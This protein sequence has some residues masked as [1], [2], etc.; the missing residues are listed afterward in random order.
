MLPLSPF[1]ASFAAAGIPKEDERRRTAEVHVLRHTFSTHLSRNGMAPRTASR[2]FTNVGFG[3]RQF[4]PAEEPVRVVPLFRR[5]EVEALQPALLAL[6]NGTG[7]AP[8]ER[9]LPPYS[10]VPQ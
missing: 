10:H 9:C 8:Q 7:E 2:L 4:L 5:V 3:A 6:R 1:G